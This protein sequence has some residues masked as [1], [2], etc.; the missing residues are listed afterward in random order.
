MLPVWGKGNQYNG[1][2]FLPGSGELFQHDLFLR[3]V[4]SRSYRLYTAGT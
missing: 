4:I 1:G 2:P 3:L